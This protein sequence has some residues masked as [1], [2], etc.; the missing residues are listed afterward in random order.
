MLATKL[1]NIVF[2]INKNKNLDFVFEFRMVLLVFL[3]VRLDY[4]IN[5]SDF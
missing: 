4:K 1:R 2:D 5:V 3:A